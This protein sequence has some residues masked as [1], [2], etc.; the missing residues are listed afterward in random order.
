MIAEK[1]EAGDLFYQEHIPYLKFDNC[2][3]ECLTVLYRKYKKTKK[4]LLLL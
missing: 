3:V 1:A 4:D 2:T